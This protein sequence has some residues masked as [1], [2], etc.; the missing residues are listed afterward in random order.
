MEF[1][2]DGDGGSFSTVLWLNHTWSGLLTLAPN[3]VRDS[4]ELEL[5]QLR[6]LEKH[7]RE[8]VE[9]TKDV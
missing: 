7:V 3:G 4:I 9:R 2:D 5:Q 6:A 1:H 8:V